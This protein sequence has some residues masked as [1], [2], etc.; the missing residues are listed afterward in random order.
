MQ[1]SKMKTGDGGK[2]K[3]IEGNRAIRQRLMAMGL[4]PGV[5]IEVSKVAPMGDPIEITVRGYKNTLRKTE[6]SSIDIETGEQ[7]K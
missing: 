1:L 4:T 5:V 7:E 6:A 3:K 2:V